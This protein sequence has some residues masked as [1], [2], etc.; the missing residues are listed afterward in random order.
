MAVLKIY[1][2]QINAQVSNAAPNLSALTLPLSLATDM[3]GETIKIGKIVSEMYKEQ[4]D[5]EDQNTL[6]KL[7]S[8]TSPELTAIT[9]E[10]TKN[11]DIKAGVDFYTNSIK[12][13][14]F[15]SKYDVNTSVKNKFGDWLVKQQIQT[16][17]QITAAISKNSLE[18]SQVNNDDYLTNL[19]LK[20][21]SS[22]IIERAA[23]DR[24][25]ETWFN[26]PA[27]IKNYGPKDLAALRAKKDDQRL[28]F[29][30]M[31]NTKNSPAS[32]LLNSEQ[33]VNTFGQQKGELYL[34][35]ARSALISQQNDALRL[36]EHQERA[37]VETQIGTFTELFNRINN[38]NTDKSNDKFVRELPSLDYLNDL[39]KN[40][41]INS[42]QYTALLETW[43]GR[44]RLTDEKMLSAINAQIALA[45]SVDQIDIIRE[46]VNLNPDIAKRLSI[47]DINSLNKI[48]ETH[49]KDRDAFQ[50]DVYYR[51]LLKANL[52]EIAGLV[53]LNLGDADVERKVKSIQGIQT[54]ND[55]VANGLSPEKAYIKTIENIGNNTPKLKMLP[56]PTY[57]KINPVAFS[58]DPKKEL[59]DSRVF[60]SGRYKAGSIN[61]DQFKEDLSRI[62][63][64]E[65]VYD[66]RIRNNLSETTSAFGS[67]TG[68]GVVIEKDKNK[69]SDK[70]I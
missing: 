65:Q 2:P 63:V 26:T 64:M 57:A 9:S 51:D 45:K 11:T 40:N 70:K 35:K 31:Y 16:L 4:K 5:N 69:R 14:D 60:L 22:N 33:I 15:L 6:L 3:A 19:N 43:S 32:V 7:I 17:P 68:T 53:K 58:Q 55:Y 38:Y 18:V 50:Q 20:R 30:I 8:D 47:K 28:E 61:I 29:Q 59:N 67:G 49:K 36:A 42:V 21:S 12:E 56:Q 37:T 39:K 13:K 46:A 54:Y 10:A 66:I 44:E 25:Y 34:Q 24:D 52:G 23:A 41:Q 62:D 27:N 1:E 48:F